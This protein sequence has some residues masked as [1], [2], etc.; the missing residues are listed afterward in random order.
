ML[1]RR[2]FRLLCSWF[3][4]SIGYQ[5]CCSNSNGLIRFIL[6]HEATDPSRKL[7]RSRTVTRFLRFPLPGVR[8]PRQPNQNLSLLRRHKSI[9]LQRVFNFTQGLAGMRHVNLVE[10]SAHIE[11]FLRMALNIGGLPLKPAGW[12]MNHDPG[13]WKS[14]SDALSPAASRSDPMEAA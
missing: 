13:I 5:I 10:P 14:V 2:R 9:A 7:T 3:R 1:Y 4:L 12:L 11:N 8:S 6:H